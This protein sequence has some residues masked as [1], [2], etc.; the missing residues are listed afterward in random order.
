M[1]RASRPR[2][3]ARAILN[4]AASAEQ[5]RATKAGALP[6]GKASSNS[7]SEPMFMWKDMIAHR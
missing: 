5:S 1:E 6:A 7:F 4:A 2:F 3:S